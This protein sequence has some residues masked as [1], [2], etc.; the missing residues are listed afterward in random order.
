MANSEALYRKQLH[1]VV[2]STLH[3]TLLVELSP[4]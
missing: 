4:R 2:A 1:N 3:N